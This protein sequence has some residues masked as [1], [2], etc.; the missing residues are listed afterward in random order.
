MDPNQVN[1]TPMVDAANPA[2]DLFGRAFEIRSTLRIEG[3]EKRALTVLSLHGSDDLSA[4]SVHEIAVGTTA[5]A[6]ALLDDALGREAVL[7]I[8]RTADDD[9]VYVLRGIVDKIAPG[10]VNVGQDQRQTRIIL[11]PLLHELHHVTRS[12]VYQNLTAVDIVNDLVKPLRIEVVTRL[13]PEPLAR[14]YCTQ[15]GE[16]DLAFLTR[17]LAEDGIHF[18]LEHTREKT[19]LVLV[20]DPRGYQAI[21]GN[22]VLPYRDADGAV[23][24]EH[25]KK[26]RREHRVRA[27]SVAMRDYNFAKP[28]RVMDARDDNAK[29][30]VPGSLAAR[31]LYVHPGAYVDPEE[32]SA[33]VGDEVQRAT[34][35]GKARARL[36]LEAERSSALTFSGQSDSLRLRVGGR[37]EITDHADAAFNREYVVISASLHS[38][39][40]GGMPLEGAGRSSSSGQE[41]VE[42]S[43]GAVS[44]D[45]PVRPIPQ[46]KPAAHLRTARV[47]G[48]R[49]DEPYVD[50]YGRIK[51]QFAW[52]RE[53]PSNEHSSCWV[54]MATPIAHHN[55]GFYVAHRVGAEVV[56]DFLDGDVD[57]PIVVG[58]LFHADNRPPQPLPDDA[59]RS[60]LYRGLS[61]PGNQGKNELSFEDKA[62]NEEIFLHAQKNHREV[63]L[64]NH[65]ESVGAS[66]SVSVGAAQSV[67]VGAA[68]S[69][70]VGKARSVTVKGGET[71]KITEKRSEEV[72]G[73]ED[74]KV[75]SG[76]SHTVVSGNEEL[77]VTAGT[78]TVK[79]SGADGLQAAS[80]AIKITETVDIGAG[81]SITLHHGDDSTLVLSA[82]LATLGTTT[83]IVLSNPSGTIT[84]EGGKITIAAADE[85]VL[86]SGGAKMSLKKDGT[87]S[88]Q[89]DVEVG[90]VS[91]G[92]SLKLEPAQA[93]L[94]AS[95][96]NVT[97]SGILEIS[98][99]MV[100]IN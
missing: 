91:G 75:T 81:T 48:P 86:G 37:F 78:R 55:Q 68:Q 41:G 23:T 95:A 77:T 8:E 29:P 80:Q 99:A 79:V 30:A 47:V 1:V 82:G 70:T 52:D 43:F 42:V 76:R 53:G 100:K 98:G 92:S 3:Q 72:G 96:T 15:V 19:V 5:E 54:R 25:V 20:N 88:I 61:V 74:V 71:T 26:I 22:A 49:E 90:I 33:G 58:A 60:V 34:F 89:G 35:S 73:G 44:A 27:G 21:V 59:T 50:E 65:T 38:V 14:E 12:R 7:T 46:P 97:A 4:T 66:Q 6:A 62:G 11:V 83:K 69:I 56:V 13:R 36:R 10:G 67:S 18:H 85:L 28:A 32:Q 64:A 31:E 24:L 94:A 51:I 39:H 63:I 87:L 9:S 40:A 45:T 57:R 17:V 2:D 93:A 16:T 84:M